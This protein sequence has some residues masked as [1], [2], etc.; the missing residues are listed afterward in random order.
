[1]PLPPKN[2]SPRLRK[3]VALEV[4]HVAHIPASDRDQFC[5]L[6]QGSVQA[7]WEL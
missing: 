5:E 2:H 7:V 1:M 4:A 6:V 3:E